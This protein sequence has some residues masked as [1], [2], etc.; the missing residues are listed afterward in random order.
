ME[1]TKITSLVCRLF[2]V[3]AFMLL[4]LAVCEKLL[5]FFGASIFQGAYTAGRLVE[6]A[7]LLVV[8]VIAFLLRQIRDE[9]KKSK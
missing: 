1:L 9:L 3:A 8:F 5:L 7:A 6:F 4:A 2:F